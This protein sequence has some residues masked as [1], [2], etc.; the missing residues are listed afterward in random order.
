MSSEP[1][2]PT[3]MSPSR[4]NVRVRNEQGNHVLR[5]VTS[6]VRKFS[7]KEKLR[8]P[9]HQYVQRQNNLKADLSCLCLGVPAS[10]RRTFM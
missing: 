4:R 5:H 7:G 6:A 2:G 10:L 8:K 3:V 9:S 1:K